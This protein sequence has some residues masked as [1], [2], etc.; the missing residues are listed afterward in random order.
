MRRLKMDNVIIAKKLQ[1]SYQGFQLKNIDLEIPLGC[2]T[3][4]IGVNGSGKT[5]IVKCLLNLISRQEGMIQFWGLD[6]DFHEQEIKN[7]VGV[8]LGENTFYESLTLLEMKNIFAAAYKNW[9][10][11]IF[12]KYMNHFG[13]DSRKKI[14]SLSREMK[15]Q[16][17][18]CLALS[19]QAEL[20]IMD[21][22]TTGLDPMTRKEMINILLEYMKTDGRSVLFLTHTVSDLDKFA[23]VIILVDH[24][25]VI[26]L[27]EKDVL[28]DKHKRIRGRIEQLDPQIRKLFL[29]IEETGYGFQGICKDYRQIKE[30]CPQL[31]MER[32]G[33]ENIMLAYLKGGVHA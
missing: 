21:E 12:R 7:R 27:E 6:L 9:R 22:P 5:T 11:D 19:H 13:L 17:A 24:G 31:P 15:A 23:D 2:V 26:F 4:M 28:E 3:G 30:I 1:K 10:E 29:A 18:L 14:F 16:F 32:V 20:L 33:I 8:V 25:Q